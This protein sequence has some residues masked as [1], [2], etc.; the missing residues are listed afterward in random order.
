[1]HKCLRCTLGH[2]QWSKSLHIT[3]ANPH[4][5]VN[6]LHTK[7][8]TYLYPEIIKV[9]WSAF[10]PRLNWFYPNWGNPPIYHKVER[11]KQHILFFNI[12]TNTT[13]PGR[14]T[15][16][17]VEEENINFLILYEPNQNCLSIFEL[18]FQYSQKDYAFHP[19]G[20]N[21]KHCGHLLIT[22][23]IISNGI[24]SI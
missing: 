20:L 14:T 1:M 19:A 5:A 22:K 3:L 23:C 16:Q 6:E 18:V 21:L 24:D 17:A 12:C 7:S 8:L 9:D 15:P 13:Y 2:L 11:N 10:W 4:L